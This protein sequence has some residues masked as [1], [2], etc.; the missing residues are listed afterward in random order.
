MRIEKTSQE[1]IIAI[2]I[3]K[4]LV[5]P[6]LH[7]I[8]DFSQA[9]HTINLSS[10]L[11]K[12]NDRYSELIL[13]SNHLKSLSNGAYHYV[14]KDEEAIVLQGKLELYSDTSNDEEPNANVDDGGLLW[15]ND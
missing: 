8:N 13:T 10:Y 4:E 6:T 11:T 12:I 15:F 5:E 2:N 3:T 1:T 9:T 14:L 7:L